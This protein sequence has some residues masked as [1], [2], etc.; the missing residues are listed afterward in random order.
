MI[1]VSPRLESEWTDPRLWLMVK[2]MV[3]Q[4]AAYA[5]A[6]YGWEFTITSI[7]RTPEEDAALDASGVH[8]AW[9]AIDVR[10]RDVPEAQVKDV[11]RWI[12]ERY[13]YD[14]KR[15]ALQCAVWKPH[16]SGPH[17]HLQCHANTVSRVMVPFDCG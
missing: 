17:L 7:H 2:Q 10:T 4:A 13:W 3:E 11:G 15:L 14:P 6:Q 8:V 16:G 9:R 5:L 1:F 12:N